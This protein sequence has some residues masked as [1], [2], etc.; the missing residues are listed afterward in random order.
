MGVAQGTANLQFLSN[1]KSLLSADDLELAYTTTLATFH[2][3]HVEDGS[4]VHLQFLLEELLD[5]LLAVG[6]LPAIEVGGLLVVVVEY[7][8]ENLLVCRIAEGRR[9]GTNP[10]LGSCLVLK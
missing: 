10:S 8:G 5:F 1:R 2:C 3:F 4:E 7:L 9:V 6:Y